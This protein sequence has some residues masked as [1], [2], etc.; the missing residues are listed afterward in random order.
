MAQSADRES[1]NR[2]DSGPDYAGA[3][4]LIRSDIK[5]DKEETSRIGQRVGGTWKRI[6]KTMGLNRAGAQMF[7][8]IDG[9]APE[10]RS[11]VLR[12]LI[13]LA[14]AARYT[15]FNDLVDQAQNATPKAPPAPPAPIT[16]AAGGSKADA[17]LAAAPPHPRDDSDLLGGGDDETGGDSGGD[18]V[19]E[20]PLGIGQTTVGLAPALRV[21]LKRSH[22]QAL[23]VGAD[24]ADEGEWYDLRPA[25]P[26]E[27]AAERERIA[28]FDD[29][30]A[31]KPEVAA[32]AA[33]AK[34]KAGSKPAKPKKS[35]GRPTLGIAGGTQAGAVIH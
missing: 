2:A 35:G 10:S 5:Q 21:D 11:D 12:T 4:Q 18:V 24:P 22:I 3:L 15:D 8:R 34:S 13:G 7:A 32:A 33:P 26:D 19:D 25:T 29:S 20:D 14:K 31:V 28:D 9:M 1:V 30:G 23:R 6:E 16:P 27:L 17:A